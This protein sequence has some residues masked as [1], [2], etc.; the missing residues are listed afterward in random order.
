[1]NRPIYLDYN[2]TTPVDPRVLQIMLPYFSNSFGNAASTGHPY[3]W[4]ALQAVEK[5]RKQVARGINGDPAAIVWTS[6]ATEANN[7]AIKGVAD[8]LRH[9][10]RHIIT[11][12]TEH[13]SVLDTT[14]R[15]QRDGCHVTYLPVDRSGRVTPQQIQGAIRP[16]TIL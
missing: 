9:R 10:G 13:K 11:Q 14:K 6:G 12:T 2:A 5:A 16:D 8:A 15:L 1:M 3:G 7:L 4:E